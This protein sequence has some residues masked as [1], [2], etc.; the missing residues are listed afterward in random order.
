MY[1]TYSSAN[2]SINSTKV[3]VVFKRAYL[4]V[5]SVNLDLG[6]GKY[7]TATEYL[8]KDGITNVIVDPYNRSEEHNSR[9]LEMIE[10]RGGADSCTLSNV[11]NVIDSE[12]ARYHTLSVAKAYM[13]KGANLFITVY[14]GDRTGK[15]RKTK[16]DCWQNNKRLA[17]Y[18]PEV[19]KVFDCA[20]VVN[21]MIIAVK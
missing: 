20:D 4:R 15:G 1:Q 5:G 13:K 17:D 3:P 7:D 10:R 16:K 12:T 21:G 19:L 14:E 18:L 6:G 9:S 11:L 8:K 2:T